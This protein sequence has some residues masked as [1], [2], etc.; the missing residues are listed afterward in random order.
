MTHE[1]TINF[2][3]PSLNEYVNK[4][5]YSKY[6]GAKFKRITDRNICCEIRAQLF[7]LK[8]TKPVIVHITYIEENKRRDVDNIYSAAKYILDGLVKMQVLKDDSKRYVIDVK[9]SV[10]YAK[11]S[12]VIV[13][14]EE[15]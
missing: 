12:K 14:L 13:K 11:E 7:L 9:N 3:L 6:K 15:V 10:Q 1:F 4:C 5:R 8:I 2:R